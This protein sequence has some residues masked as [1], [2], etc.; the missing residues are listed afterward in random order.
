MRPRLITIGIDSL[1]WHLVKVWASQGRLPAFRDLL[2]SSRALIL[3]ES[4]RALPGAVWTD[5][6]TG[7]SAAVHGYE[8]EEKLRAGSYQIERV[9]SSQVSAAPFYRTLSEAGVRCAVIDFPVDY[10]IDRFNGIQVVDWGTEFKLWRF[11]TRPKRLAAQLESKYGRHP[12]NRYPGTHTDLPGL[13]ALK[14]KLMQGIEIKRRCAVDLIQQHEHDFI[15]F[16]FSELHKAGHFLWRFHDREHPDFTHAEPE[17]VDSLRAMYEGMDRALGSVLKQLK[18]EDDLIVV[19]DRGMCAD[20]RGDHLVDAILLKLGLAVQRAT[21]A[22]IPANNSW[23]WRL[24]FARPANKVYRWLGRRMISDRL[25]EALLP[26]Y[27]KAVGAAPPL[28][29]SRTR[30]FRMPTFGNSYLRV[31]LAG[32]EPAGVVSPGAQYEALLSNLAAQF[33]AL[34]NPETGEPAV[35]DVYFPARQLRGPK[36]AEL[37]DVAIVWNSHHPIDAVTSE[38]IGTIAGR[39]ERERSGNHR[40]EGF[41]LF[42]GPS[43]ATGRGEHPGDAR[44]LAPA[45]LER[46]RVEV[47][48][49]Y[50]MR[51]PEAV[52]KRSSDGAV[53]RP[54]DLPAPAPA[55]A[56][57]LA[58]WEFSHED[59]LLFLMCAPP[60]S[61][62]GLHRGQWAHEF[63]SNR[64]DSDRR[65]V[66]R[67]SRANHPCVDRIKRAAQVTESRGDPSRQPIARGRERPTKT[68]ARE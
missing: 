19:T 28:D 8:H 52:L 38:A 65:R 1:D 26:W 14:R 46:F 42:R 6:A 33:R 25:R 36:A 55:P 13:L 21:A 30:V 67:V 68:R 20:H 50:E 27:R 53:P 23:P 35:E 12:L 34:I 11:E 31:N 29:W 48:R 45:I 64:V 3:G 16:G 60:R 24:L 7:C 66:C 5:I 39:Q 61:T 58:S 32:R 40:P 15:F 4:N 54:G 10:P 44:Q 57:A 63:R 51:P 62:V 2:R 49:H 37:P 56:Q 22:K 47:P 9:D 59:S 43:F 18:P 41:A 17:L